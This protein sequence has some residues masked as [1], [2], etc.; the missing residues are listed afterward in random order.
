MRGRRV[1]CWVQRADGSAMEAVASD[2]KTGT[3]GRAQ[4]V[5]GDR[6]LLTLVRYIHNNPVKAGLVER[7]EDWAYSS[8]RAYL[9]SPFPWVETVSVLER[10]GGS[11]GYA[12]WMEVRPSPG[13][14]RMFL[15]DAKGRLRPVVGEW[16]E[17]ASLKLI[18]SKA[19]LAELEFGITR[20]SQSQA[21]RST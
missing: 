5:E 16:T 9:G 10:A 7:M 2:V 19:F 11:V 20:P 4:W 3:G 6:Y 14:R 15:P 21:A 17:G 18:A 1:L 8:H 13:E 12:K